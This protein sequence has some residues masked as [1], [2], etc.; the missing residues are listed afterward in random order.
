M[1]MGMILFIFAHQGGIATTDEMCLAYLLYYPRIALSF[2][3][4]LPTGPQMLK[5]LDAIQVT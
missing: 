5:Y 4:T 2:C 1:E 3:E